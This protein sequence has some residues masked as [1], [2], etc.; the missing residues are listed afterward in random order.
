MKTFP[1]V[2]LMITVLLMG[3]STH[4]V[5]SKEL[6]ST[7]QIRYEMTKLLRSEVQSSQ[8]EVLGTVSDFIVDSN[9]HIEFAIL[10]QKSSKAGQGRTVAIPFDALRYETLPGRFVL[11]TTVERLN[12]APNF[13]PNDL[14]DPKFAEHV[15][16][17]FGLG[18]NW[19][20]QGHPKGYR[21]DQDPFDLV[22]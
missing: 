15:D 16:R 4:E 20:E 5:I 6:N 2:P 22:G 11:N 8:G 14:T 13:D 1:L 10:S 17:F 12:A 21:S 9:G 19:T 7:T 18:P 3:F